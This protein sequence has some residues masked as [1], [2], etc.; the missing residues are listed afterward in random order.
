MGSLSAKHW[1]NHRKNCPVSRV[2]SCTACRARIDLSKVQSKSEI[3]VPIDLKTGAFADHAYTVEVHPVS[4]KTIAGT[5]YRPLRSS[6][7]T[8]PEGILIFRKIRSARRCYGLAIALLLH[9]LLV[10]VVQGNQGGVLGVRIGLSFL[11]EML[12]T[13]SL[14]GAKKWTLACG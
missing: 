14:N 11:L 3:K 13:Y 1:N 8:T 5:S 10:A 2:R 12:S 7:A 4:K 6:M 9:Q